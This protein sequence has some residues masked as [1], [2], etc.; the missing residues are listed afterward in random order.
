MA[1]KR[2]RFDRIRITKVGFWYTLFTLVVGLAAAN[3]GNNALY[4]VEAML[5]ALLAVSGFVSRRNLAAVEVGVEAPEEVY[6]KQPFSLSVELRSRDR[7]FAKRLLV[8]SSGDDGETQLV[9]WLARGESRSLRLGLLLKRRGRHR[10][11]AIRVWSI[12]PLGL[13]FK[14]KRHP[15]ELELLVYPEIYPSEVSR[16]S[17]SG[18]AGEEP[19][20]DSGW[21]HELL[22]LRE[23]RVGD[24]PRGI[25]WK[26]SARTGRMV[27][28]EREAERG[29]RVSI[30]FDNAVG[31]IV[32]QAAERRFERLVSEAA[33]AAAHHLE[34][35]FDVQL[36]TREEVVPFG[37]GRAHRL[38]LLEALAL[39]E[40]RARQSHS[41][42]GPDAS[43]LEF[44]PS[45]EKV[46]S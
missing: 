3:T 45:S 25:H 5:L 35:G 20:R 21:G 7:W 37:R 18:R 27:Y 16:L 39:I 1:S 46:A 14:S 32:D 43:T 11:E 13:I 44:R 36:V 2:P 26:Q 31:E 10:L 41:L 22:T 38:R 40:P 34:R 33:S 23:F 42:R 4:M 30:V 12:F 8:L 9:P 15:V 29:K 24:D 6:A 28:M 17:A 19:S